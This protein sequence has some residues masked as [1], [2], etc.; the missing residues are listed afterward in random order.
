MKSSVDTDSFNV[1]GSGNLMI[2]RGG[3]ICILRIYSQEE[4]R[5]V[6]HVPVRG[7]HANM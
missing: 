1:R 7:T 2:N 3:M 6:Q 4:N 5:D